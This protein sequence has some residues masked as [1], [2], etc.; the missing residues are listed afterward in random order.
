MRRRKVDFP[1][2]FGPVRICV[3]AAGAGGSSS[4][5]FVKGRF[6]MEREWATGRW[7]AAV[8]VVVGALVK[9]GRTRE[10]LWERVEKVARTSRVERRCESGRSAGRALMRFLRRVV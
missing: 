6:W 2:M 9:V 4:E 5:F 7:E 1:D 10:W 8:R 3:R